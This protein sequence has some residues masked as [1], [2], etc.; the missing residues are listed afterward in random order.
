ML[1]GHSGKTFL[2]S[3]G[4][5]YGLCYTAEFQSR[6]SPGDDSLSR[7]LVMS[8]KLHLNNKQINFV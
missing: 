5:C 1:K 4:H 3:Y 8:L 7:A 2:L 6:E